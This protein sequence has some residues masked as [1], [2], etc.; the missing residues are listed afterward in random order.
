[1]DMITKNVKHG[2]SNTKIVSAVLNTNIK[3][4]LIEYNC[5]CCNK[6]YQ[7]TF[8]ENL[9]KWSANI[10]KCFKHH[11]NKLLLLLRKGIYPYENIGDWE[12]SSETSLPEKQYFYSHLNMED[13]TD[14]D[15]LHTKRVCK[16]FE[17]K[18]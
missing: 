14:S 9:K 16:D 7:K 5:L 13:I 18:D 4:D 15:Y 6:N 1:M 10:H 2:E 17:I 3:D 11:T 12:K 8:D